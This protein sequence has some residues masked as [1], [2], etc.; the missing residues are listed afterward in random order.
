[1]D[2]PKTH[3]F[4]P[5]FYLVIL[6][7]LISETGAQQALVP[8]Q[9]ISKK[10]QPNLATRMRNQDPQEQEDDWITVGPGANL[11][12]D[13]IQT[14]ARTAAKELQFKL[15]FEE[16]VFGNDQA[17]IKFS[18][19]I[20]LKPEEF[21]QLTQTILRSKGLAIV[22]TD[23]DGIKQVIQLTRIRPFAPEIAADQLKA[24]EYLTQVYKLEHIA[25][26]KAIELIN[27]YFDRKTGNNSANPPINSI[28][29]R[30][31]LIV[32][33]TKTNIKK[34]DKLI[35]QF[36]VAMETSKLEFVEVGSVQAEEVVADVEKILKLKRD[37]TKNE[38]GAIG[39]AENVSVTAENRTNRIVLVGPEQGVAQAKSL[40]KELLGNEKP[41][42]IRP[43]RF[44][45]ITAQKMDEYIRS[46]LGNLTKQQID[47]IYKSK[48]DAQTNQLVVTTRAEIHQQ[49]AELQKEL[50][51]PVDKSAV[52]QSS[53]IQYYE[54]KHVKAEEILRTIQSV[55][56]NMFRQGSQGGPAQ[57][58]NEVGPSQDRGSTVRGINE[59]NPA[60][61]PGEPQRSRTVGELNDPYGYQQ[62]GLPPGQEGFLGRSPLLNRLANS[63]STSFADSNSL[64]P[65]KA[66]VVVDKNSNMLIV[67]AEPAVQRLY[68]EL[69]AKLDRPRPQVL[70][71][72][73]V[74]TI[75]CGDD[76]NLGIEISS[77]D[78]NGSKRLFAFT[79]YGLST[80]DPTN[81]ALSILPGLG[82]NGTLIDADIADIVLRSLATHTRTRVVAAPRILVNDN[83]TG[84][85]SSV[86]EVPYA[87]INASNTVATTTVG[88]FAEAGTTITVTPQIGE[89]DNLN[90]EF[91]VII[92]DFT[93]APTENLP[94][95]RRSDQVK[96]SV[97]IP[98]GHTVI[99]GGLRRK[100]DSN[101]RQGLPFVENV[102]VF[103]LLSSNLGVEN[104]HQN[105]YVFIKPVILR[106]DKFRDLQFLSHHERREARIPHDLPKSCPILIK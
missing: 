15:L 23:N 20:K 44:R 21:F 77:G 27:N 72:V 47:S 2:F 56:R 33:E 103:R 70:V 48:L 66:S 40:I 55:E 42:L 16:N 8:A 75:D 102:P 68:A 61:S 29:E 35:K 81:G 88:G 78:R 19:E 83:A 24:G 46:S 97:T 91:D 14:M 7:I 105:I 89:G 39:F 101:T 95:P 98:D 106:D 79:Q 71:E 45:F 69:I 38:S 58:V 60:I 96:S 36:D 49:I 62:E 50:D 1:M 31:L 37:A 74:V 43:Y 25:T 63:L 82:F 65:G 59:L 104:D 22:N 90:L 52:K 73:T 28:P 18:E 9:T 84:V 92:S 87:Q 54:I 11:K 3:R 99:V 53:P 30:K 10:S 76:A 34:I 67:N 64:V 17:P 5:M 86:A 12:L 26:T 51:R 6:A 41:L 85:L 94:P 32:T 4:A 57:N 100:R 93:D 80:V 13:S